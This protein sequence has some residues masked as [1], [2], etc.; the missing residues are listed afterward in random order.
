M[1]LFAGLSHT[2]YQ[3]LLRAL[4]RHLDRLAITDLRLIEQEEGLTI[5]A[6]PAADPTTGFQTHHLRDDDLLALLRSA[7]QLRGTGRQAADMTTRFGFTYQDLLRAI[8]RVLDA[9]SLRDLRLV[10]QP[11]GLLIQVTHG[12]RLLRGFQTYRL[13]ATRVQALVRDTTSQR[14]VSEFGEAIAD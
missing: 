13:T 10:E 2:D 6:R 5:Q 14:G 3:D 9:E 12:G 1:R 8:G 7:Y 4:G 11:A